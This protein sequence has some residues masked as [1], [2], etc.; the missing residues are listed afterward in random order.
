MKNILIV[1]FTIVVFDSCTQQN[2]NNFTVSGKVEK[3]PMPVMFLERLPFDN[4]GIPVVLD[5]VKLPSSGE[6]SLHGTGTEQGLYA[7]TFNHQPAIIFVNDN[8]NITINYNIDDFR[9]PDVSG[10]EATKSLYGFINDYRAKDSVAAVTYY[11]MD[12]LH[13]LHTSQGDSTATL[14]QPSADKQLS[15]LND[16]I[17]NFITKSNSPANI[18]FALDKAK[19]SMMPDELNK[20]AV[21]SS[22]RFK[23]HS[24]LAIFKG[25][26][27]QLL[28]AVNGSN[29][30]Y[31]LLNKPAPDLTMN[32]VN[33]KSVSISNF[34]GKYL[35][36]DFWASWC[37]PCRNENPNVV[38]A[39]NKF[40]D[41]NFAILGVSLDQ[42]KDSWIEA[43]KKDGLA[44]TQISDLKYWESSA[45][46]AYQFDAIPFNVLIDPQGKI[47]ASSLRG[48][49]LED[50]L[51]EV[52]K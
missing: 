41:K 48:Q 51:T 6:Y 33:G 5:S 27:T 7:L 9:K 11:A 17:R 35:L 18:F 15:D 2:A 52:L 32:D 39:Y 42:E 44:W 29:T 43:I 25:I 12:S 37:G 13:N 10:S 30:N 31:A 36:V 4:N 40:K 34:R 50:K 46:A 45:V 38:A 49:A 28:A 19:N 1:L 22:E 24:G 26:S 14:L 23:E 3:A 8:N 47:I 20:L 21:A 16:V